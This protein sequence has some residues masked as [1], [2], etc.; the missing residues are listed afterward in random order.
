M[1]KNSWWWAERLPET[2]RVVISI[3]LEFSASVGFIHKEFLVGIFSCPYVWHQYAKF[4]SH[5]YS[6]PQSLHSKEYNLSSFTSHTKVLA[7]GRLPSFP[8]PY[9]TVTPSND[10]INLIFSFFPCLSTLKITAP[11]FLF[12]L[13]DITEFVSYKPFMHKSIFLIVAIVTSTLRGEKKRG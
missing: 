6:I 11:N 2:C 10:L 9:R 5:L 3:K 8:L 4:G 12:H 7:C 13:D 1:A